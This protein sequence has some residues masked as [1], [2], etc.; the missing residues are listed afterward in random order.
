VTVFVDTSAWY[1]AADRDD[2]GHARAA[3]RLEEFSGRLLTSDHVLV[4]TWYLASSRLGP[5]VAETLVNEI[6]KGIA[7]VEPT[8]LADL[9]VAARI[10]DAFPD[11][12]FSIVDR[13]SWSVMQ[14]LGLHEAIAFD[15]DFSIYRYGRDRRQAF[16][17][18]T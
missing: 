6:R 11:Q 2:A 12:R 13:T 5:L 16:T 15:H 7:R 9:E 18:H 3:A 17:V 10:H 8:G 1:A 4:E 14:R